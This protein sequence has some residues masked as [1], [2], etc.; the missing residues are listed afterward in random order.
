MGE[1]LT[2]VHHAWL[3]RHLLTPSVLAFLGTAVLWRVAGSHQ[4][5]PRSNRLLCGSLGGVLAVTSFSVAGSALRAVEIYGQPWATD[6]PG[7]IWTILPLWIIALS[8][9]TAM[10]SL[11]LLP[12]M[13]SRPLAVGGFLAG[14]TAHLLWVALL[15]G[16]PTLTRES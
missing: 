1:D 4:G 3:M 14:P 5:S 8:S 16:E 9:V 11:L 15:D 13:H 7:G 2:Y 12:T 6:S 10:L